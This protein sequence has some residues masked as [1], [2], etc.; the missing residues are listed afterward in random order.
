MPVEFD[1]GEHFRNFG[2][3]NVEFGGHHH[4][5]SLCLA[6]FITVFSFS[7]RVTTASRPRSSVTMA[8]AIAWAARALGCRSQGRRHDES[9]SINT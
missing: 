6:S 7:Q 4:L 2:D 3:C 1:S 8:A 9:M 5:A